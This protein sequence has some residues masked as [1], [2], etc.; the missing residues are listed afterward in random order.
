MAERTESVVLDFSIDVEDS[1]VSIKK[2]TDANKALRE[3]RK[4]LNISSVEG[5]K[6]IDE[7]N[8]TIDKN[9]A[10]IKTN[11]SAIEQQ[12]INI[13]N[14]KSA[15]DGIAPGLGKFAEGLQ[16][17]TKGFKAM[18]AQ[19]LAF[20]ATPIGLVIA[21]IGAA[22]YA[23]TAYFK[24]SEEGQ[25]NLNKVVAV[26]SAI[27]EQFM[28]IVEAVGKIIFDA[29]SNPKQALIDFGNLVKENIINRFVGM[30]EFLPAIGKAIGL[31]FEGK[32]SEAG[33]VAFDAVAKV[34]VGVADATNKIAGFIDSTGKLIEVGRTNGEKLAALQAKIARDERALTELRALNDLEVS[35]LR[36]RAVTLE[37]A[38]RRKAIQ[39]AIALEE[40]LSKKEVEFAQTKLALASLEVT[41]NGDTIEALKAQ[42][43]AVAAVAS[44]Q[45]TAFDNTLKFRKQLQSL[46]EESNKLLEEKI[47]LERAERR[48]QEN[49]ATSTDDPL[50]DAFKTQAEVRIN[51]E[52]RMQAD[53][54]KR[55]DKAADD[56]RIRA[57]KGLEIQKA[58]EEQ[59]FQAAAAVAGGI[60]GLLNEQSAAYKAF[61]SAQVIIS[62]YA[63]ATKAYEAAF[64]PV[65]TVASPALGVAFAAAA[66]LQGLANL[67]VIN[68]VEFAEGG[69]VLKG[70]S[71]AQGGIPIEAEGDEIILTKGVYRN[72]QLRQMASDINVA[73][74]GIRFA[75]GGVAAR[76]ISNP[77][78]QA[79]EISNMLKNMPAPIVSVK[80]I[81]RGQKAV[82]IKQNI[83]KR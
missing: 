6:R 74:G 17:G 59:K 7:I 54:K 30:L 42:S 80:E 57:K 56:D 19:A 73:G 71:H 15:L 36:E 63:A 31:L 69:V 16:A 64:L 82:R 45:K 50:I 52:D 40:A 34:T 60:A 43:E 27:F 76:A 68:G 62:T 70:R 33:Q 41:A 37:G 79:F 48:Q 2:L 47:A 46:D 67:A 32:F 53:L 55:K 65:P 29:I 35:K 20:I 9:T 3:E 66:V 1:I 44:A 83:S 14:Y 39:E 28:N 18:T 5:K 11:V 24:G 81:N 21:A 58:V 4:N 12:K 38:A 72:P 8:A 75:D 10:T 61:A 13:G 49:V 23:L 77:I 25:N 26:G 51:I 22:L 78:N